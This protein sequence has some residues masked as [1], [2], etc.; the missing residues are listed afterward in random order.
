MV[1]F[2]DLVS[3]EPERPPAGAPVRVQLRDTSLQ[4]AP[5][6]VLAEVHGVVEEGLPFASLRAALDQTC[7]RCTVWV[8]VDVDR[9]GRVSPG[10]YVTVQSYPV[11][12]TAE[13]RVRVA[14]KRV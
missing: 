6:P 4:D 5:A 8:H 10:D 9:D 3:S 14:V 11:T 12:A 2:V 1:V 7:A 13:R